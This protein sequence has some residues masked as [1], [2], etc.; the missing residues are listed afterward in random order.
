M[1]NSKIG[2]HVANCSISMNNNNKN[3]KDGNP[4]IAVVY[5]N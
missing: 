5:I 4:D 3:F 1:H 2:S